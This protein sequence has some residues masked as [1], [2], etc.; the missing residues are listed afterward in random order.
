MHLT[1]S[2]KQNVKR[3]IQSLDSGYKSGGETPILI[4]DAKKMEQ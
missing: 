3:S 1:G 4:I 2:G